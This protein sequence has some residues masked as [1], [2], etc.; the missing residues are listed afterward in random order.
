[1]RRWFG[2]VLGFAAAI[3]M[4]LWAIGHPKAAELAIG[5]SLAVGVAAAEHSTG[6]AKIGATPK[7][8]VALIGRTPLRDLHG[9]VVVLSTGLSNDMDTED[10]VPIQLEMLKAA[11]AKVILLGVGVTLQGSLEVNTYLKNWAMFYNIPYIDGWKDVHPKDYGV[12]LD[13]I[14]W[15]E[16][17]TYKTCGA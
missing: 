16:C 17:V 10:Y 12:V 6:Y 2:V 5:D 7:E 9:Q 15:F 11:G 1:M 13:N 4:L 14:R 3:T 8:V